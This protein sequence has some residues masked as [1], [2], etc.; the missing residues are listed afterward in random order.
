MTTENATTAESRYTGPLPDAKLVRRMLKAA[1]LGHQVSR[2][3]SGNKRTWICLAWAET[4]DTEMAERVAAALRPL[5]TDGNQRVSVVY[6]GR[7]SGTVCVR[8]NV[9]RTLS[10]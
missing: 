9:W 7:Y 10:A 2:V 8:R 6:S 1:G 4:D 5:W 3:T